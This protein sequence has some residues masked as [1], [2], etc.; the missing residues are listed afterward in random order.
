M[1]WIKIQHGLHNKPEVFSISRRLGISAN[2]TVGLL[3]K[4]WC[5]CDENSVDGCVDHLQS[6]D[7]DNV[8]GCPEF[9][10]ALLAVKWI[11]FSP[12]KAGFLVTNF[13]RHNG[14]SAKKRALKNNAQA[15]WRKGSGGDVDAPQSTTRSTK[16]STREEKRREDKS[17]Q[18]TSKAP[19]QVGDISTVKGGRVDPITG[20]V[21]QL[22]RMAGRVS[23]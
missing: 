15:K 22:D 17:L 8:V 1:A 10:D 3:V 12:Q 9:G 16:R 2:E 19:I 11:V 4:F 7:V 23:A 14:E 5:W 21:I 13:T 18:S 6:T 20:E